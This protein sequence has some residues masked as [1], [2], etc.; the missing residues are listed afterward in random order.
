MLGACSQV[1]DSLRT[2]TKDNHETT[3]RHFATWENTASPGTPKYVVQGCTAP[4]ISS[5]VLQVRA[6]S[7]ELCKFQHSPRAG[8]LWE[9]NLPAQ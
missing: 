8:A 6:R 3:P 4:A 5:P 1:H 7:F 9:P 2:G